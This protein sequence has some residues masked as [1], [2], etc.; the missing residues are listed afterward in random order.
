MLETGVGEPTLNVS[1]NTIQHSKSCSR[2]SA[3]AWQPALP[4][5]F[6]FCAASCL[7]SENETV[8]SVNTA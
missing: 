5:P 7:H 4:T 6:P 8:A 1:M 3:G 2:A